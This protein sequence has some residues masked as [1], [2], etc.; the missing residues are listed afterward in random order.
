MKPHKSIGPETSISV[1][2]GVRELH[3]S[4]CPAAF[5]WEVPRS[6]FHFEPLGRKAGP[7]PGIRVSQQRKSEGNQPAACPF[8]VQS[9]LR[10]L[11]VTRYNASA[12]PRWHGSPVGKLA[13]SGILVGNAASLGGFQW[14]SHGANR[15][16]SPTREGPQNE[17]M[18]GGDRPCHEIS[19]FSAMPCG[20]GLKPQSAR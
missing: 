5:T 7:A 20:K 2:R 16:D 3:V 1:V 9:K 12:R 6:S 19:R 15:K 13:E 10:S 14:I 8:C 4:S 11:A 17:R 18:G